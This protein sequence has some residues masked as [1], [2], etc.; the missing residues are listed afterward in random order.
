M[1]KFY[2]PFCKG[3]CVSEEER[4][5]SLDEKFHFN[6]ES[7][8]KEE[9][10]MDKDKLAKKIMDAQ[11]EGKIPCS[12]A[13]EIAQEE[14]VPPIKVGELLNELKIKIISCQLGCFK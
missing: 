7:I 9:V 12:K 11:K 13:L 6:V 14:N 1:I 2:F 5:A 10:G 4:G 3:Q 8:K